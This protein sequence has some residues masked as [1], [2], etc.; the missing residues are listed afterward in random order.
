M[1]RGTDTQ[2]GQFELISGEALVT[3][4]VDS[5]AVTV[6]IGDGR[7]VAERARF[8]LRYDTAAPCVTCLAGTVRVERGAAAAALTAGQQIGFTAD[9]LTMPVAIDGAAV[10]AWTGGVVI[11]DAMPVSEVVAEVNR[12]R[13]GRIVL[14]NAA[15]GRER[16]SARFR[17]E[18]ID[19][20]VGQIAQ[21]FGAHA[22]TLPGGV[23][24][25]G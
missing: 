14:T 12:Y 25:L 13:R 4:P 23:T 20:V 1:L 7:V 3:A 22:R 21:I 19:R 10:A 2:A 18:N 17:I 9:G 5:G 11:F 6:T 24:L 16:F 15:L 8:N